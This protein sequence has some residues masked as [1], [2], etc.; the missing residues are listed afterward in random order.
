MIK[1]IKPDEV[2]SYDQIQVC[3]ESNLTDEVE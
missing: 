2:L 1:H 3:S